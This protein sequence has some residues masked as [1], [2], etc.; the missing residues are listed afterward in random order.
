MAFMLVVKP[1]NDLTPSEVD[2]FASLEQIIGEGIETVR[3]VGAALRTIRDKRLYRVEFKTFEDYCQARWGITKTHA[4]RQ[5]SA[6][7]VIE[8]LTPIGFTPPQNEG[9]TRPL[10]GLA[11]DEQKIVWRVVS[12]TAPGGK[13][14][15]RH[16]QSVVNVFKEVSQTGALDDGSGEQIPISQV[17]KAA[18]TEENYERLKRQEAYIEGKQNP[19][20][21]PV[22]KCRTVL[23][24]QQVTARLGE[25]EFNAPLPDGDSYIVTIQIRPVDSEQTADAPSSTN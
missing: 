9:Q 18:I 2:E 23:T 5:I 12:E 3:K 8:N 24:S 10:T 11:E 1:N 6:A 13:V 20:N 19:K 15:Q 17:L 4:N 22:A 14:T 16:V 7:A 25:F 21:L